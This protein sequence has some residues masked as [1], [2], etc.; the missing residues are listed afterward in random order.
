V[1]LKAMYEKIKKDVNFTQMRRGESKDSSKGFT[2][3]S[4]D[5]E[6]AFESRSINSYQPSNLNQKLK[7]TT[8]RKP[9]FQMSDFKG[10]NPKRYRGGYG[11]AYVNSWKSR[12][13]VIK[14]ENQENM[15]ES[16]GSSDESSSNQLKNDI[17]N[18][19]QSNLADIDPLSDNKD[20][21]TPGTL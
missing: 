15:N 2:L 1:L 4:M 12:D 8:I 17:D 11:N 6:S 10:K 19:K 14:E 18:P 13:E 3:S 5:S 7:T 16:L 21:S 9:S 20:S